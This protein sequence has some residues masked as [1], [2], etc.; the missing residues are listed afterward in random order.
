[1]RKIKLN[2]TDQLDL[3]GSSSTREIT[4]EGYLKG[5]AAVTKVGVQLYSAR[6]FGVDSDE[7]VGV[8]RPPETVFH[9][10][11][12]ESIKQ[13]PITMTHPDEDVNSE[14]HNRLSVGSTGEQVGPI[15]DERLGVNFVVN[16]KSIVDGIISD[17]IGELSLGYDSFIISEEGSY[18]GESYVYRFDGPMICNHLA[19]LRKGDG[20]CGESVKILD[21]GENMF[22]KKIALKLL[23]DAGC[24]AEKLEAFMKD[25]KEDDEADAKAFMTELTAISSKDMDL[26]GVMPLIV[27]ELKPKLEKVVTTAGFQS[28][29]AKEIAAGMSGT[30][31]EESMDQEG[32]EPPVD[33]PP[34]EDAKTEEEKKKEMDSKV[35]D[36]AEK[37]VAL[38][39]LATPFLAKDAKVNEMSDREILE[40]ALKAVGFEDCKDLSDDQLKGRLDV[41][42]HDRIRAADSFKRISDGS[43]EDGELSAPLDAV[44]LRNMK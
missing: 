22:T 27:K 12:Q 23:K 37:R 20:R 14:N 31:G 3:T 7:M 34:V 33:E 13:Q 25:A 30:T 21:S 2:I 32:E 1:M 9:A 42:T 5:I 10:Q 17:E 26:A 43:I 40:G 8:F 29:L 18:N 28:A 38:I 11:T 41:L 6:D 4:K 39:T 19:V 15:D 35:K 44:T 24:P 16:D 36:A